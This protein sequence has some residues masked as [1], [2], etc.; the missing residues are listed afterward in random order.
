MHIRLHGAA[1]LAWAAGVASATLVAVA[2]LEGPTGLG[3]HPPV[4]AAVSLT[5]PAATPA[6]WFPTGD[7][8]HV[9]VRRAGRADPIVDTTVVVA[10]SLQAVVPI[11]MSQAL[12]SFVATAEVLYSGSLYFLGFEALR[13]RAGADTAVTLA[14]IYVGPGARA[15]S[16]ALALR[17]STL[18]RGDTT[19]LM[20]VVRDS[21]GQLIENVPA[22]YVARRP[23]VVAVDP[24]G[25]VTAQPVPPDT[26]RVVGWL[27]SGLADSLVVRVHSRADSVALVSGGGQTGSRLHPLAAPLTVLVLGDDG[28]PVAGEPVT[29]TAVP[30]DGGFAPAVATTD[31]EGF[32][33]S[34]WTLGAQVGAQAASVSVQD[35]ALL[36]VSA[37]ATA[38]PVDSVVVTPAS[39][40]LAALGATQQFAAEAYDSLGTSIAGAAFTWS[41]TPPGVATVDSTGLATA[42]SQGAAA[43][44]ATAAGVS[45]SA[46]LT[47][48][49]TATVLPVDS[50][51]V[52]PASATLTALG[53]TQQFAAEA[54]DSLGASIAGAAFTWSAMPASV[55]TVDSTGLVTAVSQG[56]ATITATA[57]GVSGTAQLTV[58]IGITY[59]TEDIVFISTR[60]GNREVYVMNADGSGTR[61]ITNTPGD[62]FAPAWAPDRSAIVFEREVAGDAQIFGVGAGG[63]GEV[64]LTFDGVNT[65]PRFSPDGT[66]VGFTSTRNG[67]AEVWVM[68]ADGA[69]Q[70]RLIDPAGLADFFADWAPDGRQVVFI[71]RPDTGAPESEAYV[72]DSS[73]GSVRK[74]FGDNDGDFPDLTAARWSPLGGEIVYT[75]ITPF[76][77]TVLTSRTL[78]DLDGP[79]GDVAD[80]SPTFDGNAAFAAAGDVLVFESEAVGVRGV[81]WRDAAGAI[82]RLSPADTAEYEPDHARPANPLYVAQIDVQPDPVGL[83][84]DQQRQLFSVSARD[85]SGAA[86]GVPLTWAQRNDGRTVALGDGDLV[87]VAP[88]ATVVVATYGGW[89][90]DSALVSIT[91][92]TGASGRRLVFSADYQLYSMRGDGTDVVLLTNNPG[93]TNYEPVYSPDGSRIAWSSTQ[94]GDQEIYVMNADGSGQLQL[95]TNAV[96]DDYPSWSP[97][98]QRLVFVSTRTGPSALWIMN[99]DGASPRQL[100]FPSG[101]A[102][103]D[104]AWS[105]DGSVIAF[106]SFSGGASNLFAVKPAG[107]AP[108]SLGLA[109]RYPAWTP[110]GDTVLFSGG[111]PSRIQRRALVGGS[112]L[113]ITSGCGPLVCATAGDYE[114]SA[115]S[116]GLVLFWS[117]RANSSYGQLM[118]MRADGSA[119]SGLLPVASQ[120]PNGFTFSLQGNWQPLAPSPYAAAVVIGGDATTPLTPSGTRQLSASALDQNGQPIAPVGGF[121]WA[122]LDPA[123]ATVDSTGLVT[124]VSGGTGRIV[125]ASGVAV[126][127]TVTLTVA[128]PLSRTWVGGDAAGA[129]DWFVA[130]NWSPSGVPAAGDSVVIPNVASAPVLTGAVAV[131]RLVINDGVLTVN[132]QRVMVAG[133]FQ[134]QGNGT[135]APGT[136]GRM[137]MQDDADTVIVQGSASF[138]GGVSTG[139]LSAGVLMVAGDFSQLYVGSN[140]ADFAASGTHKVILNGAAA[141]AIRFDA[142]AGAPGQS[143]FFHDLEIANTSGG[144]SFTTNAVVNAKLVVTT[145]AALTGA[146]T[147]TVGDSLVTVAGSNVTT[148]SMRVGGGM[149]VAG[150]FGP[151]TTEFFGTGVGIQAGLGYQNVVVSGTAS[152]TG[153]TTVTGNLTVSDGALTVNGQRVTVTGDLQMQGNGNG[154]V[155][156]GARLIMQN[157]ADTVLV[158]G[159]ATFAGGV[160]TGLLT[161]GVLGV[162]GDFSQLYVGSNW[163]AFAA[164]GTHKVVLNGAATQTVRF[165]SP[166]GAPGQRSFFQDLEIASASGATVT[167][168][169]VINGKLWVTASAPVTGTGT[170]TVGDSLVTVAGSSMTPAGVRLG[171]GMAING[172]FSPTTAEFFGTNQVIPVGLGYQNV[173]VTGAASFAGAVSL[174][175]ALTVAGGGSLTL[176]GA[177]GVTGDLTVNDGALT[178]NGQ[179]VTVAGNLQIQGNGNGNVGTGG[180]VLMLN[181]ADTLVVQGNATFAGGASTGLLSA[182]VLRIAGNFSQVYVGS[183]WAAFAASGTHRVILNGGAAQTVHFDSPTGAPGQRSFFH[184]LEL[185]NA[186][187]GVTLSSAVFANGELRARSGAQQSLA[188]AGN[189]LTVTGLDV[190]SLILDN[191]VLASSGG[192]LTRLDHVTFQNY[193]ATATQ[194]TLSHAGAA[195]SFTF[196]GLRFLTA[197]TTGYYLSA[198]DTASGDGNV[199]T[200]NLAESDPADGSSRTVTGG[201]AV[202]NWLGALVPPF[203][204]MSAG[205]GYSCGLAPSGAPFCWGR[206]FDGS[207]GDSTTM[208]RHLP[209]PV[210]GNLS[211]SGISAG[212][213][214]ACGLT[215]AGAAYC[216]GSNGYGQLGDSTTTNSLVPVAVRGGLTFVALAAGEQHTC[217]LT[218]AGAAYCWGGNG[219]GQLGDT[220]TTDRITPVAVFGGLT[221]ASVSSGGLHTCGVATGGQA[222]CWGSNTF[223]QLGDGTGAQSEEPVPVFGGLTFNSVSATGTSHSCGVTTTGAAYCW[224]WNGEGELG[225]GTTTPSPVPVPVSGGLVF[226]SI[227]AGGSG[228]TCGLTTAGAAHCWG[229]NDVGQL[230]D[231]T[232]A[233]RTTPVAVSG[234]LTFVSLDAGFAHVAAIAQ[235]GAGYSWGSNTSGQLGDGT[236]TGSSVP[237]A[238]APPNP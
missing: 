155:G 188:G 59:A 235:G 192:T 169:A 227:S 177:T 228:Y 226:A 183:N 164:S 144:V 8:L 84:S 126:P 9:T 170:L 139:L 13:L 114:P 54:Y 24:T 211:L 94:D 102:H 2:C 91:P 219:Y 72:A 5:L 237:V 30:G 156:T 111:S 185:A 26:G 181:P 70:R 194:L 231:G 200:V 193:A 120:E 78:E 179:H 105:P 33:S 225:D 187:G 29:F 213:S 162:A 39:A 92:A 57:D 56:A 11:P 99:A 214:H 28:L 40:T 93:Y 132:G 38:L 145:A 81:Y 134:I 115:S 35:V 173:L 27:P 21:A 23:A 43:I 1:W 180:R 124:A 138:A 53:A 34:V 127:D 31:A 71:R 50:V 168:N 191:V 151:G 196:T 216:W 210:S 165:D 199:F 76:G 107:G 68:D 42:V 153:P 141:Q 106:A 178:L 75:R 135:G 22:R 221:F 12:E 17:D 128:Q 190:D 207:L 204:V 87:A 58:S 96:S 186:S 77:T 218:A 41:A 67:T 52:T 44:T 215:P 97:D 47:V 175:G 123:V 167:T 108:W 36:A 32:A 208:E 198:T 129:T 122:A 238:V 65:R 48:S 130:A 10:D 18:H 189:G 112:V 163:A 100:T 85:S 166:A 49:P 14:A 152:L 174:P 197:P 6:I 55:A 63:S 236:T 201:G 203:D 205:N 176:A 109:G 101:V 90:T 61:R 86:V 69:N 136:G 121:V 159:N 142:P 83:T 157:A 222:Y 182:G 25:V 202:V 137:I 113:D 103:I 15:A 16:Y 232:N 82:T 118:I 20:P 73:G 184:H 160:T 74:V 116:D 4:T 89:R 149:A 80:Q 220:T 150:T 98:G 125:L 224:G 234:G 104:P 46:Q 64:Q 158:Q 212:W 147:V 172:T 140:W 195:T 209:T 223:G 45:G 133:D 230:G 60:D 143:S 161:A 233:P 206:N 3:S 146:G 148:A 171:G 110:A 7:S 79:L 131:A 117:F 88:G 66:K 62:E 51:V 95:T 229:L 217:G 119:Q 19:S 154:S 37:I